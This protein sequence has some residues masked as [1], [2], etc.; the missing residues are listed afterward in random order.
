LIPSGGLPFSPCL[1]ELART[2]AGIDAVHA[3]TAQRFTTQR[4]EE[5]KEKHA[6]VVFALTHHPGEYVMNSAQLNSLSYRMIG[7]CIAVH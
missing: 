6:S 2:Q 7:A 3:G 5:R 1:N 4:N